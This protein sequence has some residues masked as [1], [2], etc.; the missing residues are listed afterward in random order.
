MEQAEDCGSPP[1]RGVD[2]VRVRRP[3]QPGE[4]G[5]A[6]TRQRPEAAARP[7]PDPTA[8]QLLN[9]PTALS[10]TNTASAWIQE[11]SDGSNTRNRLRHKS[12]KTFLHLF[13]N[14]GRT[15]GSRSSWARERTGPTA[16]TRATA[17]TAQD[18]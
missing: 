2:K 1:G 10:P 4:G 14:F 9:S 3:R 7:R 6:G 8:Y 5:D 15:R 13:T 11:N 12:D 18:S 17:A 16:T